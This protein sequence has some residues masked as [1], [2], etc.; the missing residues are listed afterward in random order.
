MNDYVTVFET[1]PYPG[2]DD[3]FQIGHVAVEDEQN[4][5]TFKK[6][7]TLNV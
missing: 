3:L 2:R 4:A 6:K 5:L 1:S 7:L